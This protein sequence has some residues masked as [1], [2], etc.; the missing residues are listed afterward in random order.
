MSTTT[1]AAA[2]AKKKQSSRTKNKR[3]FTTDWSN[4]TAITTVDRMLL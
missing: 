3:N 2:A 1:A 4:T